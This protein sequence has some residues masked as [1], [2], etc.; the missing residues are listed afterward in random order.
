MTTETTEKRTAKKVTVPVT[1]TKSEAVGP[2]DLVFDAKVKDEH[3]TLDIKLIN[4]PPFDSRSTDVPLTEDFKKSIK[5][6]GVL[7]PIL[8]AK[9][10]DGTYIVVA[11]R[12]R[13]RAATEAGHK[14]IPAYIKAMTAREARIFCINENEHRQSLTAWDRANSYKELKDGGMSQ[15]EIAKSIGKSDGFVSQHLSIFD[16][17]PQV[18]TMV[19]Q[20]K[21]EPGTTA[22]VRELVRVKDAEKQLMLAQDAVEGEWTSKE[23]KEQF[24]RL[25]AKEK[26]RSAAAKERKRSTKSEGDEGSDEVEEPVDFD[27]KYAAVEIK[28]PKI[29][30]SRAFLAGVEARIE[31]IRQA[32]EVDELKLAYEQG[33]FDAGKMLFGLKKL[34]KTLGGE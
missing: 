8:V 18:Q 33:M 1:P 6:D 30:T 31:R 5:Q 11:G 14:E 32:D 2:R 16:L 21:F 9:L 29:T 23:L 12:R 25:E 24:D 15:T 10:E 7:V 27:T 17:A 28:Q 13:L 26:A 4:F 19:R 34:P 22:K 3:T 20:N